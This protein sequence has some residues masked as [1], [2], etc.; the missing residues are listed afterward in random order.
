MPERA[1]IATQV[2]LIR[3]MEGK[4]QA[5]FAK[6][7]HMSE[8]MI[9]NLEKARENIRLASLK[10]LAVYIRKTISDFLNSEPKPEQICFETFEETETQ[11][12]SSE[13]IALSKWIDVFMDFS[14]ETQEDFAW[15]CGICLDNV[16]K[17]VRQCSDCNPTLSTLQSFAA[18]MSV[19][20]SELLDTSLSE[21]DMR[22]ILA[23]RLCK[24]S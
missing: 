10:T 13:I 18:Y 14:G 2:K 5:E 6:A 19:T 22:E 15:N 4:T 21:T 1:L 9:R 24:N 12:I 16:S 8:R 11:S 23:E 7:I 20:V 17:I 3:C